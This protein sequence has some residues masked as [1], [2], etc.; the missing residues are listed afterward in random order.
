MNLTKT[1]RIIGQCSDLRMLHALKAH[2]EK[3]I[4]IMR[5]R[6]YVAKVD[7]NWEEIKGCKIGDILHVTTPAAFLGGTIQRGDAFKISYIQPRAK[8]V[9]FF[10][11]DGKEHA[12]HMTAATAARYELSTTPSDNPMSEQTRAMHKRVG[13]ELREAGLI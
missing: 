2:I 13:G 4:D 1:K 12:F 11:D 7:K 9:W 10:G 5:R 8:R 3:R 6:E